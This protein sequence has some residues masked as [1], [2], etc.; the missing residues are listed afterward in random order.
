MLCPSTKCGDIL[1]RCISMLKEKE[2][3]NQW[4]A[5]GF[6]MAEVHTQKTCHAIEGCSW[7]CNIHTGVE[8]HPP[9]C[10]PK[11]YIHDVRLSEW[12]L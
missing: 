8:K 6:A 9:G 10:V 5:Q 1:S 11:I 2:Y 7:Q 12:L 4:L 3:Y